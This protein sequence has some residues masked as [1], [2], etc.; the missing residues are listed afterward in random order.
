MDTAEEDPVVEEKATTTRTKPVGASKKR[1]L[2]D[3]DE[4]KRLVIEVATTLAE[5]PLKYSPSFCDVLLPGLPGSEELRAYLVKLWIAFILTCF[6][7]YGGSTPN[8]TWGF[9]LV[10]NDPTKSAQEKLALKRLIVRAVLAAKECHKLLRDELSSR[11]DEE[12]VQMQVL[13]QG[14]SILSMLTCLDPIHQSALVALFMAGLHPLHGVE[15]YHMETWEGIPFKLPTTAYDEEAGKYVKI[16]KSDPR[17]MQPTQPLLT[18]GVKKPM[19]ETQVVATNINNFLLRIYAAV[20]RG[21]ASRET[22]NG[23]K[24]DDDTDDAGNPFLRPSETPDA[25][26][27]FA[28]AMKLN[29]EDG[30]AAYGALPKIYYPEKNGFVMC[31]PAVAEGKQVLVWKTYH[32]TCGSKQTK[33]SGPTPAKVVAFNSRKPNK[34]FRKQNYI[35]NFYFLNFVCIIVGIV[36]KTAVEK[37]RTVCFTVIPTKVLSKLICHLARMT[38]ENAVR[39]LL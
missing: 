16:Q 34:N 13:L 23:P 9:S 8:I 29:T 2:S 33:E 7:R 12:R 38:V 39:Y 6:D 10:D 37:H 26:D 3:P 32:A 35:F 21:G 5:S 15:G 24:S 19:E 30:W 11:T 1:N 20:A 31:V 25:F 18:N 27:A 36:V 28:K 14:P 22:A 17:Y 4:A